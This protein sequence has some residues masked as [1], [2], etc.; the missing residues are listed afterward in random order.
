MARTERRG[1]ARL[2]QESLALQGLVSRPRSDSSG[3]I[4]S[5]IAVEISSQS[6][7]CNRRQ[8]EMQNNQ[9]RPQTTKL[10]PLTL[11]LPRQLQIAR[12]LTLRPTMLLIA[13]MVNSLPLKR[14]SPLIFKLLLALSPP[15]LA[16]LRGRES[17]EI[18]QFMNRRSAR[19]AVQNAPSI[20]QSLT[21]V[22]ISTKV[23][24]F[25]R[26]KGGYLEPRF[27]DPRKRPIR[28]IERVSLI[29]WVARRSTGTYI[30]GIGSARRTGRQQRSLSCST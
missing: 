1:R 26:D 19:Q 28:A 2:R 27:A 12:V 20:A 5:L 3:T 21:G 16:A 4:M 13:L 18:M 24:I 10:L 15:L 11:R 6:T 23:V 7:H 8:Q 22:Y 25:K 9:R 29:Q 30:W 14:R 17:T